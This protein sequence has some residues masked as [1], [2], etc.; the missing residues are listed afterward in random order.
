[1]MPEVPPVTLASWR[2][3]VTT[4]L[5]SPLCLLELWRMP[6]R[7]RWQVLRAGWPLAL[8]GAIIGCHFGLWVVSLQST[9]LAHAMLFVSMSPVMVAAGK[10]LQRQPQSW[11]ELGG[12]ALGTGGAATL[13]LGSLSGQRGAGDRGLLDEA[14]APSSGESW[15]GDLAA[16]VA[17]ALFVAYLNIGQ[18]LRA[19]MPLFTY[20]TLVTGGGAAVLMLAGAATEEASLRR[21][22]G[23]LAGPGAASLFGWASAEY[24]PKIA[25]LALFPGLL[26]HT[27]FNAL[28]N[29]MDP[30]IITLVLSFDPVLG[31]LGG[32]LMGQ[33]PPPPHFTYVGGSIVILSTVV[34]SIASHRRWG[35]KLGLLAFT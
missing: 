30:L 16:L 34:V 27:G 4:L 28:V 21:Q 23:S 26:G 35:A 11:G 18:R 33:V 1:M 24:G 14:P 9:S 32:Y 5:M 22:A 12:T 3:Q 8:N 17:A 13:A 20:A 31:T 15:Q 10:A 25:W 29:V 19:W 2:L 6:A 7:L